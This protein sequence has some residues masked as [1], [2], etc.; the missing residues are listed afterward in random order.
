[1]TQPH[2]LITGIGGPA[3]TAAATFFREQGW[4]ITSTDIVQ[5][6]VAAPDFRF[7]PR[8][9]DPAFVAVLLALVHDLRPDLLV[10]TVSEELQAVARIRN[11]L[12]ALGTAVWISDPLAVVTAN[13]KLLTAWRLQALGC[14]AP[15]TFDGT[16]VENPLRVASLLGYPFLAKPRVGRGGRGVKLFATPEEAVTERRREIV[17]QEFVP[18]EEFDVNLFALP[19]GQT[20]TAVVLLKTG[21]KE[22]VTGNATGVRRVERPD[23]VEVAL[24]AALKLR[25]EGPVDMDIRLD[26]AGRPKILDINARLGANVLSA[27]EVLDTISS[28]T[29]KWMMLHA[30]VHARVA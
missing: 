6:T 4:K 12:R 18:G 1:M 11:D 28:L 14:P 23:V 10:P 27:R 16:S 20:R 19:A 3:G 13:D 22:G 8:G 30:P 17:Y 7:V 24:R 2:V 29:T 25:L 15:L 21:M 9:G 5:V 26:A